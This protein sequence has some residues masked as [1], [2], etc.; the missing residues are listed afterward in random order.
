VNE[1]VAQAS[2]SALALTTGDYVALLDPDGLLTPDAL[3]H[4]AEAIVRNGGI[5]VLYADEDKISD[6]G[7][8]YEPV[9][10]GAFSPELAIATNYIQRFTVIRRTILLAAGGFR[11]DFEGAQDLDLYLRVIEQ[12]TPGRVE[13]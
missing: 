2:N 1:S 9:F 5:D 3:L 12:T 6:D 13:H 7:E 8:R 4:V 11:D 10:Q